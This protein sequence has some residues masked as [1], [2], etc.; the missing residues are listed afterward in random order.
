MSSIATQ[1]PVAAFIISD[2]R[3]CHQ[4][5]RSLGESTQSAG[6]D[7]GVEALNPYRSSLL[8]SDA[9]YQEFISN[10]QPQQINS[11]KRIDPF[12]EQIKLEATTALEKEPGAGPQIYQGILGRSGLKSAICSVVSHEI[13]TE[14]IP[15]TALKGLFLELLSLEDE[16]KI[17]LDLQAV[18]TR[19]GGIR[20][21]MN[22]V[23][24]HKGFH[25]LVC[26][27]VAHRLWQEGRTGL[28]YYL[29]SVISRRF[30]ADIHP[31]CSIG[32]GCYLVGT[33]DVVGETAVVGEDVTILE[34]V[35]LGGTGKEAGDRHPKIGNGVIIQGWAAVLGNIPVG[36]GAIVEAKSIVTKAVPPLAIVSGVPARIQ[37][38]RDLKPM[39][40]DDGAVEEHLSSKYFELWKSFEVQDSI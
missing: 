21:A 36:D 32:G 14:L 19:S 13:E 22:A 8:P 35:T 17:R 20:N 31:A 7:S 37:G 6:T 16:N 18:A 40:S 15:A 28:A 24:F 27:R 2:R 25:A 9:A 29:Q 5:D 34:G 10:L 39:D 12:W 33:G 26:Y 23:L 1:Y 3:V 4:V 38:Y 11:K 30:S